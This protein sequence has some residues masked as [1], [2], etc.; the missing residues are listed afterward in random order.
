MKRVSVG[1]SCRPLGKCDYEFYVDDNATNK[2]INEKID[3]ILEL[4]IYRTI[5][6]GF[7]EHGN[8]R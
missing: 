4:K 1:V 7:D 5:E 3:E 8:K 2:E 6:E